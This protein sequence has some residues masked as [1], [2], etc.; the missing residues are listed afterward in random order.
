MGADTKVMKNSSSHRFLGL[1]LM[2]ILTA[3]GL[4]RA[5]VAPAVAAGDRSETPEI[6]ANTLAVSQP[7]G[8]LFTA[9]FRP[10]PAASMAPMAIVVAPQGDR[11]V[12]HSFWDRQNQI[13]FTANGSLAAAD[14]FVTRSNLQ[15]SGKE[16]NPLTRQLS[17]STPALA[18]N[19]AIETGG[20]IGISYLFHKTGHHKLER[21]CSYVNMS[22]SAFAV[23]YGLAHR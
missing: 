19:F 5:Q 4:L 18:A 9:S 8:A 13:L 2:V 11:P 23:G 10:V 6:D 20:V 21:A 1:G 22:A 7:A 15:H 16:M 14:F 12:V 17:G 3:S